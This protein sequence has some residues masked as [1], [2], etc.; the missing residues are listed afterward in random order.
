MPRRRGALR[1]PCGEAH[2]PQPPPPSSER[3]E[4]MSTGLLILIATSTAA[5]VIIL[6]LVLTKLVRTVVENA[7]ELVPDVARV[8]SRLTR[9]PRRASRPVRPVGEARPRPPR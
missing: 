6:A 2:A 3:S 8:P 1:H 9:R 5:T 7:S 4:P